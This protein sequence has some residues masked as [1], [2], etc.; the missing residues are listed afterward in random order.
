MRVFGA[1]GAAVAVA[2]ALWAPQAAGQTT[3]TVERV[4]SGESLVVATGDG[5]NV[6]VRL[7]GID[8]PD[9][10]HCGGRD[11]IDALT[12]LALYEPVVLTADPAVPATDELGRA[13]LYADRGGQL[14]I[15]LELVRRGWAAVVDPPRFGRVDSYYE[16]EADALGGV[17]RRCDGDFALDEAAQQRARVAAAT[18]FVRRYYR[19]LANDQYRAAWRMLATPVKRGLGF[20]FRRWRD[21]FR[22]SRGVRVLSARGRIAGGGPVVRVALRSSARD[23][24][25]GRTVVQRFRGTVAVSEG[26]E[27]AIQRFAVR[28]VAGGT[29]RT[30]K[31]QCPPPPPPPSGGGGGDGTDCQGY[32]PCIPP[33]PDVDCAGGSGNGPRYV[34]GPVYVTGSDPYGLDSDGDGVGC[35]S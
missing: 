28:K 3:G 15:G 8:T 9:R 4:T 31:S 33:G 17:W 6:A 26:G 7:I 34:S 10:D 16:A 24:C 12:E 25:D 20:S 18:G 13:L 27:L 30:S 11:A 19:R 23:V 21:G 32:S 29:P 22:G 35:E 14:D 5:R 2:T 1:V